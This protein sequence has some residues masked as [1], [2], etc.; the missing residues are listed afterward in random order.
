[1]NRKTFH[2]PASQQASIKRRAI[3]ADVTNVLTQAIPVREAARK[4]AAKRNIS[5]EAVR[6]TYRQMENN[7][8]HS[9]GN[10]CFTDEEEDVFLTFLETA[11]ICHSPLA[12][13]D[14]ITLI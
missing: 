11:S 7:R 1:M 13:A 5:E 10:Q 8:G 4:I 2:V 6:S 3:F 9:H 12:R 14:V